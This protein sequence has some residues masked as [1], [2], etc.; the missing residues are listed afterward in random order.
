MHKGH[1]RSRKDLGPAEKSGRVPAV[2]AAKQPGREAGGTISQKKAQSHGKKEAQEDLCPFPAVD[3]RETAMKGDG[4]SRDAGHQGMALAG[5]D[6]EKPGG[7]GP[8]DDGD[9]SCQESHQSGARIAAE[10]CN[11]ID[12]HGDRGVESTHDY[13]PQEIADGGHGDSWAGAHGPG[14]NAGGDGAGGVCPA[15]DENDAQDEKRSPQKDRLFLQ[16]PEKFRKRDG[17]AGPLSLIF[18]FY[19][20]ILRISTFLGKAEKPVLRKRRGDR[21]WRGQETCLPAEVRG[22]DGGIKAGQKPYGIRTV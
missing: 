21:I 16:T 22:D 18:Y 11:M 5:G 3:S 7:G 6:S 19:D 9:H 8:D 4:C 20:E 12:G 10:V 17:H 1:G 15:V 14:G 13:N 2:P